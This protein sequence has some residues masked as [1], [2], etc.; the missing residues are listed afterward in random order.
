ME[1]MAPISII[2]TCK[3]VMTYDLKP[4]TVDRYYQYVVQEFVPEL[5]NMGLYMYR[6]W[7]VAY[8]NYPIRQVEFVAEDIEVVHEV[9][10]SDRWE[11]L[12]NQLETY[13]LN[14]NRKLLRFRQGFQF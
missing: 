6:V 12:E 10:D 11:N 2:P 3:L 7:H 1:R 4:E 13:I 5:Q 8:G 9:L 14:Y